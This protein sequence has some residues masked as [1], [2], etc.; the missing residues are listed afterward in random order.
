M[1]VIKVNNI[2]SQNKTTVLF[3]PKT[4]HFASKSQLMSAAADAEKIVEKIAR[5]VVVLLEYEE[6]RNLRR[7]RTSTD[8]TIMTPPR[9]PC[10]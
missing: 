6:S 4:Q 10:S 7:R 1:E 9:R 8:T 2:L 5:V 3:L